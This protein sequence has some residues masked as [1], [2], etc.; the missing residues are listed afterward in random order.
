MTSLLRPKAESRTGQC[1]YNTNHNYYTAT[2]SE[3]Y[4]LIV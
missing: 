4:S 1:K 2:E 3:S